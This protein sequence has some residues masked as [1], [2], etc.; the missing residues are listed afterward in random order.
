[1]L[2]LSL[3]EGQDKADTIQKGNSGLQDLRGISLQAHEHSSWV[4]INGMRNVRLDD[5]EEELQTILVGDR[6]S[7]SL[8]GMGTG[9]LGYGLLVA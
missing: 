1:M 8:L 2:S 5:G 9:S 3:E 6:R 7:H 4:E